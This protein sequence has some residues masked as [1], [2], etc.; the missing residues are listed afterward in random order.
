MG[1]HM[2]TAIR[3]SPRIA[4]LLLVSVF[5]L[6]G[7]IGGLLTF[8]P[9]VM[10]GLNGVDIG[11]DPNLLSELRAPGVVLIATAGLAG[12]ES[13]SPACAIRRFW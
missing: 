7:T 13:S 3:S 10:F 5:A 2:T 12:A 8:A 9:A 11:A 6:L 4:I 1:G